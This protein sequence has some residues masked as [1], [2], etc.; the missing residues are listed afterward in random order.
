MGNK[1]YNPHN[2]PEPIA[3]LEGGSE[4]RIPKAKSLLVGM[5]TNYGNSLTLYIFPLFFTRK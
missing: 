1:K 5:Q 3:K 4:E 2:I